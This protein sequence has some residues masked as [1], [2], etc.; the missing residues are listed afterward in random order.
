VL[1]DIHWYQTFTLVA[2]LF[3]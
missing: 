3:W 1:V 2:C